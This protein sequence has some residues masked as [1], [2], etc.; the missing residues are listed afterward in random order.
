MPATRFLTKSGVIAEQLRN[1]IVHG[2]LRSGTQL[3]QD[4]VAQRFGMSITPVREAFGVLEA[5]GL[6][7]LRPHKGVVV[8]TLDYRDAEDLYELRRI[9]EVQ[10]IRRAAENIDE[11]GLS[12]L[13]LANK[14]VE[15]AAR[16]PELHQFRE[17]CGQFHGALVEATGSKVYA[18]ITRSIIRLSLFFVPLDAP[19]VGQVVR[20]HRAIIAALRHHDADKAAQIMER[21]L[22]GSV[23]LLRRHG[24]A[25]N[26]APEATLKPKARARRSAVKPPSRSGSHR[27]R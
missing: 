7:E 19:R 17:L 27:S 4:E 16:N 14:D 24:P 5:E 18:E 9:L 22:A 25:A 20:E 1:E 13:E 26:G 12:N 6:L 2:V 3:E 23:R 10:A 21:H 11:A 15:S 8:A